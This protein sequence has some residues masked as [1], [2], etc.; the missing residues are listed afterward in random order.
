ME[1]WG[2]NLSRQQHKGQLMEASFV[3]AYN[4]GI[5]QGW[6]CTNAKGAFG[7]LKSLLFPGLVPSIKIVLVFV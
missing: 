3:F 2:Q 5:Y 4:R 1:K 6:A 7:P